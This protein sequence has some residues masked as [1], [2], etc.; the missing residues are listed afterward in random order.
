[1][2]IKIRSNEKSSTSGIDHFW[3]LL[4]YLRGTQR[5]NIRLYKRNRVDELVKLM[6]LIPSVGSDRVSTRLT[7]ST[8]CFNRIMEDKNRWL[9]KGAEK[10]EREKKKKVCLL[11]YEVKT[12][13][14]NEI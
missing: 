1:M 9:C 13:Y 14:R 2:M 5:K 4:V 8:S 11:G 3:V 10:R 12:N 7:L 6:S